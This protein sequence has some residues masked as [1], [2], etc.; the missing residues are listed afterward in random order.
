MFPFTF[1]LSFHNR[2]IEKLHEAR[3]PSSQEEETLQFLWEL[4]VKLQTDLEKLS[5]ENL[6]AERDDLKEYMDKVTKELL[7]GRQVRGQR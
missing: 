1:P 2:L 5:D 7:E 4:F 3:S 6:V